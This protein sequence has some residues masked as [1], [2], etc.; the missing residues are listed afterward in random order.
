MTIP[1]YPTDRFYMFRHLNEEETKEFQQYA[2]TTDP[3][4]NK[5]WSIYHPVCREVW[6]RRGLS[7]QE[8]AS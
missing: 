3:D 6:V 8:D 2:E 7:P 4:P 1:T 5:S